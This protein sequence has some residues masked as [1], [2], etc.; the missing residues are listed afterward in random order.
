MSVLPDCVMSFVFKNI[1]TTANYA[2]LSLVSKAVRQ[3]I[4]TQAVFETRELLEWY[5]EITMSVSSDVR[6]HYLL[7]FVHKF[8][9]FMTYAHDNTLCISTNTRAIRWDSSG[10]ITDYE[11][12]SGESNSE[13]L[14]SMVSTL[15]RLFPLL[16]TTR[17]IIMD[18]NLYPLSSNYTPNIISLKLVSTDPVRNGHETY[19]IKFKLSKDIINT[20]YVWF[21]HRGND[22]GCRWSAIYTL[23]D[24]EKYY[25]YPAIGQINGN[26]QWLL[27]KMRSELIA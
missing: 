27:T 15:K 22:I 18:T 6:G 9:T 13:W 16:M 3:W 26:Y 12:D 5:A 23:L 8:G 7:P 17:P 4:D 21:N 14:S 20:Y 24:G 19:K 2:V 25:V 10:G 11:Y 1:V